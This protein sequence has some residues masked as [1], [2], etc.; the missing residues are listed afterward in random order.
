M[1]ESLFGDSLVAGI[2][3]TPEVAEL[4]HPARGEPERTAA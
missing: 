2:D 1:D 3:R 4:P